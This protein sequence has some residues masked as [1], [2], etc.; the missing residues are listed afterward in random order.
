MPLQYAPRGTVSCYN[1]I[2]FVGI[3]LAPLKK[4]RNKGSR[5]KFL[6]MFFSVFC[7]LLSS[8]AFSRSSITLQ[9]DGK[10][11]SC[12]PTRDQ[13][14]PGNGNNIE[15]CV[16]TAYSGPFSKSESISLCTGGRGTA[17]A[18]C[19]LAAYAGPF[20]KD[21]TMELCTA[22]RTVGPA[23]CAQKLYA[24]PFSKQETMKLCSSRNATIQNANCAIKAYRSFSKKESIEMCM[25]FR[26]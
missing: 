18:E 4:K 12:K 7:F 17:P 11:Y 16:S 22:A 3:E 23:E 15:A 20:S 8:S 13:G 26:R 24:G 14:R 2:Y 10:E 6:V 19:A 21:E 25:P 1:L 5:L 9:I